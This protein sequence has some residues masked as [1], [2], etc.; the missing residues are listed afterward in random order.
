M[1]NTGHLEFIY[2]LFKAGMEY[3]ICVSWL[4]TPYELDQNLMLR[5]L[6]HKKYTVF[7]API[8]NG[9]TELDCLEISTNHGIMGIWRNHVMPIPNTGMDS[10]DWAY[11]F[12][13][14]C[15]QEFEPDFT[16][17][18]PPEPLSAKRYRWEKRT[19]LDMDIKLLVDGLAID[20]AV[21]IQK[22]Y[23]SMKARDK[24]DILRCLP[25]NLFNKEF[26][27]MRIDK[28]RISRNSLDMDNID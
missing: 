20:S 26:T 4:K 5:A 14:I 28:L 15:S 10:D 7:C 27:Y 22:H 25:E 1:I 23:R 18:P 3:C 11:I 9:P 8:E 6:Q 12:Q 2:G 16:L 21:V 17:S 24:V 13:N 19:F